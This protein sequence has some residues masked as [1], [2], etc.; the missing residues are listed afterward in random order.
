MESNFLIFNSSIHPPRDAISCISFRD[1]NHYAQVVAKPRSLRVFKH[2]NHC[3][4]YH[5]SQL[6]GCHDGLDTMNLN[7]GNS[8]YDTNWNRILYDRKLLATRCR[9]NTLN[10]NTDSEFQS[11][12]KSDIIAAKN[13]WEN[14]SV[15][16]IREHYEVGSTYV[17]S[18]KVI[19]MQ[20]YHK[21]DGRRY[22]LVKKV[23]KHG[24]ESH[25]RQSYRAPW[26]ITLLSVKSSAR[27]RGRK[28]PCLSVSSVRYVYASSLICNYKTWEG[29]M[30]FTFWNSI[31]AVSELWDVINESVVRNDCWSGWCLLDF[32]RYSVL[33]V[34]PHLNLS[35]TRFLFVQQTKTFEDSNLSHA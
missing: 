35:N 31:H 29:K 16:K 13:R 15:N 2:Y 7:A 1:D 22:V 23:D 3:N 11:L 28:F 19:Q 12:N 5:I 26:M 25:H 24:I 34:S 17:E 10:F 27:D 30:A 21:D 8:N 14:D 33:R 32:L 18:H 6:R 9:S 20:K 4:S